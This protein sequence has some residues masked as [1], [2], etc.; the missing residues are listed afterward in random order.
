MPQINFW[1]VFVS[2]VV[3]FMIG[4]VWHS[5][6]LFGKVWEKL[7]GF[8]K[9]SKKQRQEM[10]KKMGPVMAV[11]FLTTLLSAYCLAYSVKSGISFYNVSGVP[12]GLQAGFWTW[13]GFIVTTQLNAVLWEQKPFKVYLINIGYYLVSF[14]VM[15]SILAV[16][17]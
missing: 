14:L 12:A 1:A 11:G 5:P 13:L 6:L 3:Y 2:A 4:W 8:D 7:M 17:Q 16:W 9:L 15:G 10:M